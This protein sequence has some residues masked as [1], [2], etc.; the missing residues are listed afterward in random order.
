MITQKYFL[1]RNSY[2]SKEQNWIVLHK[3]IILFIIL[4]GIPTNIDIFAK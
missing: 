4:V 1:G 3:Q 2:C